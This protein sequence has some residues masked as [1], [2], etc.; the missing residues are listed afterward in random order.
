VL[1]DAER[2][3]A[4]SPS[5]RE[6]RSRG[7]GRRVQVG[8]ELW[9]D[10]PR[11]RK[12]GHHVHEAT[13][14]RSRRQHRPPV[15]PTRPH[16]P[17]VPQYD[18]WTRAVDTML[19]TEARLGQVAHQHAKLPAN[20]LEQRGIEPGQAVEVTAIPV[21]SRTADPPRV[22][23]SARESVAFGPKTSHVEDALA[24]AIEGAVSA[25]RWDVVAQLAKELE[26]RRLTA[27][28]VR[29]VAD[30]RAKRAPPGQG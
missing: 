11:R 28:G 24:R 25:G 27:A 8:F 16:E 13:G 20:I 15:S 29:L 9:V 3:G 22:D 30:E 18:R 26:A 7:R 1:R 23:V 10:D 21:D 6:P 14:L 17:H 5:L 4:A 2:G 12:L 19:A